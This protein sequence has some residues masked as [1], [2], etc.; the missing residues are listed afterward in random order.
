MT[1]TCKLHDLPALIARLKAQ[2][3]LIVAMDVR[4]DGYIVNYHEKEQAEEQKE[5]I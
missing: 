4:F 5:L 3:A 2:G 1:A